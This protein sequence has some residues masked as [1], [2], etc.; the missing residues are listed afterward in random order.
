LRSEHAVVLAGKENLHIPFL[1]FWHYVA[2]GAKIGYAQRLE[3]A[4]VPCLTATATPNSLCP[5]EIANYSDASIGVSIKGDGKTMRRR[6]P[7]SKHDRYLPN[8]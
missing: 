5:G 1:G 8:L 7:A 2:Q 6:A 4:L 3:F